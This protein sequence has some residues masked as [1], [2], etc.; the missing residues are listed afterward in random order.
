MPT[1]LRNTDIL[2]NDGTTQTTAGQP[3]NTTLVTAAYAAVASNGVG[4]YRPSEGNYSFNVTTAGTNLG[5]GAGTW[6]SMGSIATTAGDIYGNGAR[7][8]TLWLRIS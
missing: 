6:R 5:F 2:F 4:A 7:F 8:M 1:T 3:T